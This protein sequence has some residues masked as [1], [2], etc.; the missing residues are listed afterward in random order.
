QLWTCDYVF[1]SL[2]QIEQRI[3][4]QVKCTILLVMMCTFYPSPLNGFEVESQ[5]GIDE[6]CALYLP[7][8]N[9]V[10]GHATIESGNNS[11]GIQI[12]LVTYVVKSYFIHRHFHEQNFSNGPT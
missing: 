7:P 11:A 1:Q 10:V 12:I 2:E 9:S 3:T 4:Y 6:S 5:I 8:R